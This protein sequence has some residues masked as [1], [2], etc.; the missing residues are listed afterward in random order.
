MQVRTD[1]EQGVEEHL[2]AADV[3]AKL[4]RHAE[5]LARLVVVAAAVALPGF[6]RDRDSVTVKLDALLVYPVNGTQA[7]LKLPLDTAEF[8]M[9]L[10]QMPFG[11]MPSHHFTEQRVG[12]GKLARQSNASQKGVVGHLSSTTELFAHG[13]RELPGTGE[14]ACKTQTPSTRLYIAKSTL[15]PAPLSCPSRGEDRSAT[16]CSVCPACGW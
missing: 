3:D 10:Y 12:S 8:T 7:S 4:V 14:V 5:D 6:E 11:V 1:F 15:S 13:R 2:L 16:L 9:L